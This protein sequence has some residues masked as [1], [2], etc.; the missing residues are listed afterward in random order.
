MS[1]SLSR[2]RINPLDLPEILTRVGQFIPLWVRE[3][4]SKYTLD[5]HPQDLLSATAVNRLFHTTLTPILWIVYNNVVLSRVPL[6]VILANSHHFRFFEN[7]Y[8]KDLRFACTNLSHLCVSSYLDPELASDLIIANPNITSLTWA[9]PTTFTFLNSKKFHQAL[10]SLHRLRH[11]K[12]SGWRIDYSESDCVHSLQY[13]FRKFLSNNSAHLQDLSLSFMLGLNPTPK[14]PVF[15]K[16]RSL[17]LDISWSEN[18]SSPDLLRYCPALETLIIHADWTCDVEA[19]AFM[20]RNYCPKLNT[21][22]CPDGFMMFQSGALLDDDGYVTLIQNCRPLST[23]TKNPSNNALLTPKT[24]GAESVSGLVHFEMAIG[25]LCKSITEALL[26]HSN[27]LETIEL[28]ICGDEIDNFEN[29]NHLLSNCPHLKRFAMANYM[30]EWNPQ[31]GQLLFQKPW[32]C[33]WLEYLRLDGFEDHFE[34]RNSQDDRNDI[35]QNG[36]GNFYD[37]W[38]DSYQDDNGSIYDDDEVKQEEY[39]E[40]FNPAWLVQIDAS[41]DGSDSKTLQEHETAESDQQVQG[42]EEKIKENGMEP[43]NEDIEQ[44][45]HYEYEQ[46]HDREPSLDDI[47]PKTWQCSM[48]TRD[49]S[50][51]SAQGGAFIRLLFKTANTMPNLGTVELNGSLYVMVE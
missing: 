6:P 12:I 46:S 24:T 16:L 31:H 29:A 49:R 17:L 43:S 44:A 50:L 48:T 38:S 1:S 14:W 42:N 37:D 5:F 7:T 36:D 2:P 33:Q 8:F 39:T 28:Y 15:P 18:P 23:T 47:K 11:L 30:L 35:G 40:E 25:L 32:I 13:Q 21:I 4:N 26:V 9:Y 27:H 10:N 34:D 22:R 3:P 19:I 20:A 45:Y 51:Y 41:K